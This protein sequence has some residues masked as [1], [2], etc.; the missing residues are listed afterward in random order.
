[1]KPLVLLAS[2]V[3]IVA[4][5][6]SFAASTVY[7]T[8]AAF[9]GAT[10]GLTTETFQ[11][12]PGGTTLANGQS[13]S[14][15]SPAP[16][17]SIVA[18]VTFSPDSASANNYIAAAGQ[19]TNPT[20]A[21]GTNLPSQGRL[22]VIFNNPQTAF[23]ADLFENYG[24]G[25]QGAAA[26]FIIELFNGATLVDTLNT[27]VQPNGGSF[28]GVTSTNPFDRVFLRQNTDPGFAVIDNVSFG[29]AGP[30]VPEPATWALLLAGFGLTGLMMRHRTRT[31]ALA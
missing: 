23:G 28:F 22:R 3:A 19:S 30:A 9:N 14:S 7:S 24:A 31:A 21:L 15:G 17:G 8:R 11:S 12:C 4:G 5:A 27:T 29:A 13:L 18:G 10:S 6:P 1:M 25:T 2:A 16:C 20:I 26:P